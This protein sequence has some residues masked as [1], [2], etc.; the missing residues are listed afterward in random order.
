M[1]WKIIY[2]EEA[3]KDINKLDNS[4]RKI[5]FKAIEK[6][7]YNPLPNTEGGYGKPLSKELKNC[8]K[9]KLKSSGIRIVY[10]LQRVDE[11]FIII[12]VGMREDSD[13]Y[14]EALK[15]ISITK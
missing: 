6:V 12:I 13:V 9:I 15:R 1:N 7:S 3:L 11:E 4:N 8:M 10:K 5:V 2:T 14:K